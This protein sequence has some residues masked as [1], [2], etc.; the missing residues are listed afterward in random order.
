MKTKRQLRKARALERLRHRLLTDGWWTSKVKVSHTE[1]MND[2]GDISQAESDK[3][4]AAWK[5]RVTNEIAILEK[6]V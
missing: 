1:A 6:R 4:F 2:G 3:A 5:A